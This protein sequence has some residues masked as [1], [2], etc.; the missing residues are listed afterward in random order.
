[1]LAGAA[2][3]DAEANSR[4]LFALGDAEQELKSVVASLGEAETV[5]GAEALEPTGGPAGIWAAEQRVNA[6]R[7][8]RRLAHQ[9]AFARAAAAR[10]VLEA[11]GAQPDPARYRDGRL[12]AMFL[13]RL[14]RS[15]LC[16]TSGVRTGQQ[17]GGEQGDPRLRFLR[18]ELDKAKRVRGLKHYG[19]L[20]GEYLRS[21]GDFLRY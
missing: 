16:G 19:D 14:A 17:G 21:A 5:A 15:E 1:M 4:R 18:E 8:R 12:W 20:T 3:G 6:E 2:E 9:A 10:G 13:F 11:L 7:T